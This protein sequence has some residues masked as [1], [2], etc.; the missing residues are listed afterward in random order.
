MRKGIGITNIL[1]S[2]TAAFASMLVIWGAFDPRVILIFVFYLAVAEM[3]V[4][5]R[6]R[7]SVICP[8]CGFDPVLY[9]K[10]PAAAAEKVKAFLQRRKEDPH[11]V[12]AK[13]LNLPALPPERMKVHEQLAAVAQDNRKAGSLISRQI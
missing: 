12:L 6:W 3:I 1:A 9:R 11:F 8:R 4:Q 7:M 10:K 2:A 13:P 5:I